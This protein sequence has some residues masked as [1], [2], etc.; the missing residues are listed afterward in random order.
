MIP[1]VAGRPMPVFITPQNAV[2]Q[3][4][5]Q[6]VVEQPPPQSITEDDIKQ[7]HEMF[8]NIDMEVIK[9]VLEA[10]NG[11]KATAINSLLQLTEQ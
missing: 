11:N 9:S 10:N 6:P 5:Q 1:N 4:A 8:P 2:P 3:Q 7:V